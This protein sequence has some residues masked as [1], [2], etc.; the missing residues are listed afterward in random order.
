M[1][2]LAN[3][4]RMRDAFPIPRRVFQFPFDIT[5]TEATCTYIALNEK[6]DQSD[7]RRKLLKRMARPARFER[8]TFGSGGQRSIQL[9]YG[10]IRLGDC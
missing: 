1:E 10:R 6:G 2:D 4:T 5:G 9:S 8:A 3:P 7:D